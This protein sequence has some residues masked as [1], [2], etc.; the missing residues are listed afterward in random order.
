MPKK[1]KTTIKEGLNPH[2][3][4]AM[5]ILINAVLGKD[6]LTSSQLTGATNLLMVLQGS[7]GE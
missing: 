4:T 2:K 3:V 7:E 6:N 5:K 1:R